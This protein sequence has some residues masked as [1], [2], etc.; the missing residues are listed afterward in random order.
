[1]I[2][3]FKLVT[4]NPKSRRDVMKGFSVPFL[5]AVLTGI[6]ILSGTSAQA[7]LGVKAGLNFADIN[8]VQEL[9]S[10]DRIENETKHGFI[11]GGHINFPLT[12]TLKLQIEGLYSVK[13]SVGNA[14]GGDFTRQK[15][16]N[17]LTYLE[18]PVL[19]KL[20][21]PTPALKPFIYGGGSVSRLLTAEERARDDWYD[22]KEKLNEYDYGLVVGGGLKLF[23]LTVEGRYTK[24]LGEVVDE[25]DQHR[26]V[27]ASKN[28]VYSLMV[29][30]D[31]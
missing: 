10:I 11:V 24:G 30:L 9:D 19:L 26:L 1:M 2:G 15:W 17:K 6:L 25:Q 3:R 8:D 21:F 5:T 22:I 13:G 18:V 20:E 31:F 12:P 14:Y 27:A 23:G 7:G 29:G 28:R 16:E 4:M